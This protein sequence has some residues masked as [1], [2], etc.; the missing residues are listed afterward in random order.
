MP[1]RPGREAGSCCLRMRRPAQI[2][3]SLRQ[4]ESLLAAESDPEMKAYALEEVN[5]LRRRQ[6][7]L[8]TKVEDMLLVDP[9]EDFSSIIVEIRAGTGGDDAALFAGDLYDMYT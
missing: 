3:E 9:A 4:A 1:T 6:E 5:A 7:E 2:G 8:K